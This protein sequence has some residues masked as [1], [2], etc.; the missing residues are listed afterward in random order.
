MQSS[1]IDHPKQNRILASLPTEEYATLV[2]DLEMVTLEL[3][4]V[5]YEPGDCLRYVHF[6][7]TSIVS[8]VFT[9]ESGASA[10]L[11]I[12]GNDGL[13]GTPLILGGDNTNHR[14]VVQSA[15][16]AYRLKADIIRWEL[17]QNGVLQQLALRY[18]QALMTQMAQS[19]VSNR[20]HTVDQ[21][22]CRWLLLSLDSLP[23]NQLDMTQELIANMLGVRREAVTEAAGKRQAAGMI[24][25]R[26]GHITVID[27]PCLEARVCECYKVVKRE[28]DRLFVALPAA[29]PITPRS[30]PSPATLRQR[31][32]ARLQ[33]TEEASLPAIPKNAEHLA[34]E[35]QVHQIE[36]ERH[37]EELRQAYEEA[38]AF[39]TRYVDIYDFAPIGYVTIDTL[40]ASLGA[41]VDAVAGANAG[42]AHKEGWLAD[43][44]HDAIANGQVVLVAQTLNAEQTDIARKIVGDAAGEFQDV[45]SKVSV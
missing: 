21:Q 38:A 10:E 15:G 12:A 5:L 9:T 40:G 20:H 43:L 18:T 6:L 24:Q 26:C 35:L 17:H 28:L 23:G 8:L 29:V 2:D 34:H 32:E 22:L 11:A 19:I 1:L 37:N 16:K 3:G 31:A 13:V 27:R 39:R 36:L 33:Q 42:V 41:F 25:Y 14:A 4:Q 30:R 45:V 7:T 44:V